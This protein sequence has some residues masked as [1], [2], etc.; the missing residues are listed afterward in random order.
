MNLHN[1]PLYYGHEADVWTWAKIKR[2]LVGNTQAD[3]S[4]IEA[5]FLIEDDSTIITGPANLEWY[6]SGSR[7]I[8]N[9]LWGDP[10][11]EIPWWRE[12]EHKARRDR[13]TP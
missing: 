6:I 2:A 12:Y 11:S 9:Y 4:H 7:L 1:F 3:I 5:E 8:N 10:V 13:R